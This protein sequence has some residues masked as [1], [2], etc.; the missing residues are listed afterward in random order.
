M[1]HL[2]PRNERAE[3][4]LSLETDTV[5]AN[6]VVMPPQLERVSLKHRDGR[7]RERIAYDGL[8]RLLPD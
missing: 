3:A 5:D 1:S 7:T 8:R 6:L 4:V 2:E